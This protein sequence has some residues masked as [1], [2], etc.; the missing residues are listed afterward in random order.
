[1]L[2]VRGG[3]GGCAAFTS[4]RPGAPDALEQCVAAVPVADAASDCAQSSPAMW[5]PAKLT[6]PTRSNPWL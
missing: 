3:R 1:V 2:A 4:V 5:L 6:L